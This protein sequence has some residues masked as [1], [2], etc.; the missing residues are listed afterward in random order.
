P[1]ETF[2]WPSPNFGDFDGDNDLD[3]AIGMR[4]GT[5]L[6][7]MRN[8]FYRNN[9]DGTFTEIAAALGV[10]DAFASFQCLLQD[11]DRDGDPDLYVSNDKG[12]PGVAWNR[13]FKN[14]G[15]AFVEQLGSGADIAIDSMGV[16]VGDLDMNGRMEIYCTNI[17]TGHALLWTNNGQSFTR[18]DAEAGVRGDA[19]GWGTV[20]FDADNDNDQDLFACSMIGAPDYLW[21]TQGNWPLV[22]SQAQCGIGDAEDSFCLAIGDIEG[23]GDVDLLMQSRLANL[24]L[25]VNTPPKGN[26]GLALRIVGSGMNRFAVGA[27]VDIEVRGKTALRE[28]VAGSLYKSQS[29]ML[30]HAG[31]G[32]ADVADRVVVRWPRVNGVRE[33]RVLVNVP[34]GFAVPVYAPS[35]VGD[36]AGDGRVDP[37]DL[38]A[39]E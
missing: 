4:T 17:A 16:C 3:L 24:R 38:A 7:Q 23:D 6:N 8:R 26:N 34:S 31:L 12:L 36:A 27:L 11:I 33:E 2:G 35:R 28:V 39:C 25:Y 29:T 18:R 13:Y 37:A 5:S 30:V 20:I 32:D 19:T 14:T 10:D 15:G 1:V 22:E 21:L 9:G